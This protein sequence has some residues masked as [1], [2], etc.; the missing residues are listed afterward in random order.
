MT[1]WDGNETNRVKAECPEDFLKPGEKIVFE[2]PVKQRRKIFH[3]AV[4]AVLLMAVSLLIRDFTLS[5]AIFSLEMFAGS[6]VCTVRFFRAPEMSDQT[7]YITNFRVVLLGFGYAQLL[8]S[9]HITGVEL[10]RNDDGSADLRFH[11]AYY[12]R[13][14]KRPDFTRRI[15]IASFDDAVKAA[16]NAEKIIPKDAY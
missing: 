9:E 10:I 13:R 14:D 4:R 11:A 16:E 2:C 1:D 6:V 15:M 12:H 8:T 5:R 7:L 3:H